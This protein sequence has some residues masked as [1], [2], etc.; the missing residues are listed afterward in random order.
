MTAITIRYVMI[1]TVDGWLSLAI[2]VAL[3]CGP[4]VAV[5]GS[6]DGSSSGSSS[7]D[8]TGLVTTD[9]TLD[10]SATV[11]STGTT[12]VADSST[13]VATFIT[14][15]SDESSEGGSFIMAPD[16]D[17]HC[18]ACDVWAQDCPDEEKCVPYACYSENE[19]DA[20]RCSPLDPTPAAPGEPCTVEDHALSGIDDCDLSA[21]CWG[22]DP[23]TLTGECAAFCMGSRANPVCEDGGR[24]CF[25]ADNGALSL[26]LRSCDPLAPSCD[27]D[28]SCVW[29]R[30][31]SGDFVCFPAA[32]V[33][34]Q[35]YGDDC[36]DSDD[37][38]CGDAL[39]CMGS[40]DVPGCA[41]MRCC[42]S[43]GDVDAPPVCPDVTQ[44]CL[45][46]YAD[47]EAPVAGLEDLCFCGV[48]D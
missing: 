6:D 5:S 7:A 2:L 31:G 16:A 32:H 39:V 28:E 23:D 17:D 11:A 33:P 38:G 41:G 4:D 21:M 34:A 30:F 25:L 43:L 27:A 44:S 42:T 8:V 10:T 1:K 40:S 47:G 13:S 14:D 36:S 22:V 45:P 35:A 3:G 19:W 24:S 9:P 48:P 37:F 18:G 26:C 29:N 15:T 12:T 20:S 46:L